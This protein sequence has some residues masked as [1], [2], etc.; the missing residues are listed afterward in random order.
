M[1]DH[2]R[3]VQILEQMANAVADGKDVWTKLDRAFRDRA[4]QYGMIEMAENVRKD[5]RLYEDYIFNLDMSEIAELERLQEEV[6][7]AVEQQEAANGAEFGPRALPKQL[8]D[9]LDRKSVV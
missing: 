5:Q 2:P 4:V 6:V 3:V 8:K 1:R 9:T 7:E